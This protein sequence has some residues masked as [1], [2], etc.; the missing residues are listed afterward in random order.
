M[1]IFYQVLDYINIIF[2]II[3]MLSSFVQILYMIAAF[4]CKK[5]TFKP[6][7]KA[8]KV[9]VLIPARNEGKVVGALINDL[10]NQNYP[11]DKYDII[12]ICHNCTDN[13]KEVALNAG[14]QVF[15]C[16]TQ[17]KLKGAGLKA[18]IDEY[19]KPEYGYDF[20][21]VLDA[22]MRVEYNYLTEMNNAFDSGVDIARSYLGSTNTLKNSVATVTSIYD[23][24]DG[25][26]TARVREKLKMNVQLIG[27]SFFMSRKL[28]ED[29]GG[30]PSEDSITEDADL[31]VKVMLKKYRIHYVEDAISYTEHPEKCSELFKRNMRLGRGVNKIFWRDGYKLL[32]KFFTT[33]K[34]TYLDIFLTLS[35]LPISLISCVWF[36]AYYIFLIIKMLVTGQP[37]LHM[38]VQLSLETFIPMAIYVLVTMVVLLSLQGVVTVFLQKDRM[39]KGH[40]WTEYI[41]ACLLMCPLM[42]FTNVAICCGILNPFQKWTPVKRTN[43]IN[44]LVLENND[45]KNQNQPT[46]EQTEQ[47]NLDNDCNNETQNDVDNIV[48]EKVDNISDK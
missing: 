22:D 44:E 30:F 26:L 8:N 48:E 21:I 17:K 20:F 3:T 29:F 42:L 16:N 1:N 31:M 32:G 46:T 33:F 47:D 34:F 5:V 13:T 15:E 11:K 10:K 35:F 36:P 24:R 6:A 43:S 37:V 2:I 45:D 27:N 14:A 4:F 9:A 41:K 19:L 18:T 7:E 23:I 40:K 25:R 39:L 12:V 28:L 38:T